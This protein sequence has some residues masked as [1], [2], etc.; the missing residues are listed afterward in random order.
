M[1]PL[2]AF[3]SS[4][5]FS[6]I[7][8][9]IGAVCLVLYCL[10]YRKYAFYVFKQK[11][12]FTK[13]RHF[14][15][16]TLPAYP[17]GWFYLLRSNELKVGESKYVDLRGENIALFRGTNG[18]VYALEA[19]CAHMGANLGINGQVTNEKC[20]RCPFHGWV[21][22][23]ETG[24]CIIGNKG[25]KEG[26]AFEYKTDESDKCTFEK[27]FNSNYE[28]VCIK[29]YITKELNGF[30]LGW[31]HSEG[32][33]PQYEPIDTWLY[34]NK[35]SYRGSS[36]NI[37]QAH[38]QDIAENGGDLMHFLYIH[39]NII[40]FLVKGFWD[41]KWLRADDPE[42]RTKLFHKNKSFNDFRIY[43]LDTYIT[44]VN[45]KF[46]GVVHLDNQISILGSRS[47]PFFSLTGF[48]LGPG[49]VYLFIKSDFFE[50]VLFQHVDTVKRYEQHVYH[51]IYTSSWTPYWFSA[52]QLR[53]EAQ[54]VLYDGVVWDNKKFGI[55]PI[56]CL[57]ND[58][59]NTLIA[60][61]KWYAQF[62]DG[63][64]KAEKIKGNYDW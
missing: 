55:S 31:F 11:K 1:I 54:Q 53:L 26:I 16:K 37:V 43:L 28:K 50:T 39:S 21:F 7:S 57:T 27:K 17:N 49:L 3:L 14:I 48:Q 20:I 12:S 45:K 61:R 63:C 4:A 64:N 10:Y 5:Y 58:A 41:A 32:D 29:K 8:I 40:P 33:K 18:K 46:M 56:Y 2:L 25:V 9:V 35:L 44:E 34:T 36:L 19:Y 42:L 6:N 47:F 59:D 38:V 15:G 30:I 62:Y 24:D 51:E 13:G 23:G 52:L 22:D 60:W